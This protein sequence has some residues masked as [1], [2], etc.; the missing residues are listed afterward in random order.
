MIVWS[1]SADNENELRNRMASFLRRG[2]KII[3]LLYTDSN[4]IK[5]YKAFFYDDNYVKYKNQVKGK[6]TNYVDDTNELDESIKLRLSKEF[7]EDSNVYQIN[8]KIKNKEKVER[9][10][11]GNTIK[12]LK[13]NNVSVYFEKVL[14]FDDY[15]ILKKAFDTK[16]KIVKLDLD[17]LQKA[18]CKLDKGI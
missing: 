18:I 9:T 3:Q 8:C 1:I 17:T 14:I 12:L 15:I 4:D 13:V 6:L 5:P 16:N 10:L 7:F 11:Y 2:F